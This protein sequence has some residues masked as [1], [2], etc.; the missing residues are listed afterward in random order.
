MAIVYLDGEG[1]G[2]VDDATGQAVNKAEDGSFWIIGNEAS[3]STQVAPAASSAPASM[4]D[5]S[6]YLTQN[7]DVSAAGV[8]AK[9][10]W[11]NYGRG[12]GRKG[13][14]LNTDQPFEYNATGD[15]RRTRA[16]EGDNR[17]FYSGS[18]MPQNYLYEQKGADGAWGLTSPGGHSEEE[19]YY[20]TGVNSPEYIQAAQRRAQEAATALDQAR[21]ATPGAVGQALARSEESLTGGSD[22]NDLRQEL[23]FYAAGAPSTASTLKDLYTPDM[24]TAVKQQLQDS[25]ASAQDARDGDDRFFGDLTP[26]VAAA[27]AYFGGPALSGALGGGTAAAVTSGA[28]FGGLMAEANGGDFFEGAVLGGATAGMGS[29]VSQSLAGSE[30][31]M[32]IADS[33]GWTPQQVSTQLQ[34]AAKTVTSGV[35]RGADLDV[36]MKQV[37]VGLVGGAAGVE[38]QQAMNDAGAPAWLSKITPAISSSIAKD[39]VATGGKNLDSI[40]INAGI[41]LGTDAAFG[42]AKGAIGDLFQPTADDSGMLAPTDVASN[43]TQDQVGALAGADS[44]MGPT[45]PAGWDQDADG[46]WVPPETVDA[47]EVDLGSPDSVEP[48]LPPG[49][50]EVDVEVSPRLTDEEVDAELQRVWEENKDQIPY[51]EP[52]QAELDAWAKDGKSW[53]DVV[54]GWLANQLSSLLKQSISAETLKQFVKKV[55]PTPPKPKPKTT[56]ST[57]ETADSESGTNWGALASALGMMQGESE[58]DDDTDNVLADAMRQAEEQAMQANAQALGGGQDMGALYAAMQQAA[59]SREK[60]KE[61][62]ESEGDLWKLATNQFKVARRA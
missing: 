62:D 12:E 31:V 24:V 30:V 61:K 35:L 19:S 15:I 36:L 7:P 54:A 45:I 46:N 25:S 38:S 1:G 16:Y 5:W 17:L 60:P 56:T 42:A 27:A 8:D 52:T 44:D 14:R 33:T 26:V 37:G 58:K 48:V 51:A 39:L 34:N 23:A 47:D 50:D 6:G 10:H 43:L 40:L 18:G 53:T 41:G 4:I 2:W 9:T 20:W 32:S 3:A 11:A 29:A 13:L 21:L 55:A 57:G 28:A 59:A 49:E 22:E